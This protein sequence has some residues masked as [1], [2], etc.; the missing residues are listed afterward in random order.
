MSEH[1]LHNPIGLVF[2]YYNEVTGV[3][4]C[5][6]CGKVI[7]KKNNKQKYCDACAQ[8]KQLEWQRDSMRKLRKNMWTFR[9]S[10]KTFKFQQLQAIV[11]FLNL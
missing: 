3:I 7:K 11:K 5:E 8:E 2:D 1:N 10:L 4:K 9:D 6:R